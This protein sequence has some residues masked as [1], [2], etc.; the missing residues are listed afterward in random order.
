[1]TSRRAFVHSASVYSLTLRGRRILIGY[2]GAVWWRFTV[3]S[4][5][6]ERWH[7]RLQYDIFSAAVCWK[8]RIE[9]VNNRKGIKIFTVRRLNI[10]IKIIDS[11]ILINPFK[12]QTI[13]LLLLCINLHGFGIIYIHVCWPSRSANYVRIFVPLWIRTRRQ[14]RYWIFSAHLMAFKML[15][16]LFESEK[17]WKFMSVEF[18]YLCM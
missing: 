6:N 7:F 18:G 9:N 2:P 4:Q 3:E 8:W 1:M 5:W 14:V 12:N 11:S 16:V 13:I 10:L 17:L 15:A